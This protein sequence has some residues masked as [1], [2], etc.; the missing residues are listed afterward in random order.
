MT[1]STPRKAKVLP[2]HVDEAAALKRLYQ[3]RV[4]ISQAAF[5][6]ESKIG[7]QGAVWQFL[8][9]HTPLNA[10]VAVKFAAALGIDVRS[11]S[12]RLADEIEGLTV[13][14]EASLSNPD[15]D[16]A[17]VHMVDAK[18]S[19]GRGTIVFAG[20]ATKELMFRQDWLLKNGAKPED[21]LAFEIEGDSMIDMHIVPGSVVLVNRKKVDPVNRKLFMLWHDGELYIKQLIKHGD[22]WLARSHNAE[23]TAKYPDFPLTAS[24]KIEGR[25]FWCGFGL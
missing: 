3:D 11:F 16:H 4:K 24:T 14:I 6:A 20:D 13:G 19:A 18:A 2:V 23:H 17:L 10:D 21:V 7:T 22:Q 8:N 15:A 12:P 5:G 9:A 25:L 1:R